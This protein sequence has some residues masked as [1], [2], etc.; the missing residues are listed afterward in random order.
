MLVNGVSV[1]LVVVSF[2]AGVGL[3]TLLTWGVVAAVWSR[4]VSREE[5]GAPIPALGQERG[6]KVTA[7]NNRKARAW[8]SEASFNRVADEINLEAK[9]D[10]FGEE[11][12]R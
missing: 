11:S 4:K 2:F 7:P 3:G 5:Q 6:L 8:R 12:V 10:A 1:A 9:G